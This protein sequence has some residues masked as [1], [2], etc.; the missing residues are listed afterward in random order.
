MRASVLVLVLAFATRGWG[1]TQV[2]LSAGYLP[3]T[4][5]FTDN[6]YSST[7]VPSLKIDH[8][9]NYRYAITTGVG[10][11]NVGYGTKGHPESM[12]Y[13]YNVPSRETI[14]NRWKQTMLQIPI[15][16]K[17]A[18]GGFSVH[19]A[20]GADIN[21]TL[22]SRVWDLK[23]SANANN[24]LMTDITRAVRPVN[25]VPFV[26][27]GY[28]YRSFTF[29]TRFM[30]FSGNW[31]STKAVGL[32]DQNGRDNGAYWRSWYY[33]NSHLMQIKPAIMI[34]LNYRIL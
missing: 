8:Y 12:Y 19:F 6:Y 31:Y 30:F 7:F 4:V 22:R 1:Q 32:T 17:I 29:D 26:V 28:S 3:T 24:Y 33:M 14:N 20:A 27:I 21:V 15:G 23:D 10:I 16:I 9:L 34:T 11:W 2:S 25:I 13:Y 18:P 5:L